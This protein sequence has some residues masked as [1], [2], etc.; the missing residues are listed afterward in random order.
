MGQVSLLTKVT[1]K[2]G[3]AD[4]LLAAVQPL[5]D[6]VRNEP[7]T[8]LY[9]MNRAKDDPNVFWFSELYADDDAFAAHGA[10]DTM[11]KVGPTLGPLIAETEFIVSEPVLAKDLPGLAF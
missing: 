9:V 3:K 10:S 7:G 8:L 5:F 1:A 2:E 11:A 4:Q 6:Q